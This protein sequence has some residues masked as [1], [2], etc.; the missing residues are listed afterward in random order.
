MI[1]HFDKKI[2]T[3]NG[4]IHENR[5]PTANDISS[6]LASGY[7]VLARVGWYEFNRS[8][9]QWLRNTGHYIAVFGYAKQNAWGGHQLVMNVSN[10]EMSYHSKS[11]GPLYDDVMLFQYDF[12]HG[13]IDSEYDP[14]FYLDG[15]GFTGL[16]KRAF[17]DGL[18]LFKP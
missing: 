18:V 13:K 14:E 1:L 12:S 17:L 4:V 9:H 8:S 15:R 5:A 7:D 2:K 16:K 11:P 10:P 6:A 3:P